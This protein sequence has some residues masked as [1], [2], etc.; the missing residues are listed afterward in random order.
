MNSSACT[1]NAAAFR[2]RT[3]AT[4]PIVYGSL[5]DR[6]RRAL[7]TAAVTREID[8]DTF[9]SHQHRDEVTA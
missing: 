4:D 7:I 8:V 3:S 9:D 6:R 5:V 2:D 1:A